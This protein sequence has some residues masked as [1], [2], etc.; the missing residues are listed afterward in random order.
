M[1]HLFE[2][3]V[4]EEEGGCTAPEKE[5]LEKLPEFQRIVSL[6]KDLHRAYPEDRH[7]DVS[8]RY[9]IDPGAPKE[10]RW[11]ITK[12]YKQGIR[13]VFFPIGYYHFRISPCRGIIYY[14]QELV[15]KGYPLN[16]N[17][18]E[19][20][21]AA[22]IEIGAYSIARSLDVRKNVVDKM[23]SDTKKLLK[24][25]DD[26]KKMATGPVPRLLPRLYNPKDDAK[27]DLMENYLLEISQE[28]GN[29]VF[30]ALANMV[31]KDVS[32]IDGIPKGFDKEEIL[33]AAGYDTS[34]AKA[35][36]KFSDTFGF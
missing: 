15:N 33:I 2:Y 26:R 25:F 23:L 32:I 11:E 30:S 28:K 1:K 14:G 12:S 4:F 35:M 17:S 9:I 10:F 27:F 6:V 18:L 8:R 20:W 31:K 13:E 7:Y 21:N 19:D 36:I 22:F 16:F 24:F 34:T 5:E 3:S 29:D